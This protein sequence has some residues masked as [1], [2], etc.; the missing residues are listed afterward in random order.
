MRYIDLTLL[1]FIAIT[2]LV[3]MSSSI[4]SIDLIL[5]SVVGIAG[6][7]WI[8]YRVVDNEKRKKT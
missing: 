4:D 1:E 3:W 6:V 2:I 5:K 8:I 7:T